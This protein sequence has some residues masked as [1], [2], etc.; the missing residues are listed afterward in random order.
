MGMN[1]ICIQK[2]DTEF[3]II[4]RLYIGPNDEWK[5]SNKYQIISCDENN[6]TCVSI[7]DIHTMIGKLESYG[8][9]RLVPISLK[10]MVILLCKNMRYTH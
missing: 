4:I 2:N 3:I 9:L 1:Q 6:E 7:C 5:Q 8:C 10:F